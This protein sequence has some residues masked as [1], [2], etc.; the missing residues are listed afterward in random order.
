MQ[1]E[2]SAIEQPIP[3]Q[4]RNNDLQRSRS[5]DHVRV[6][7]MLRFLPVFNPAVLVFGKGFSRTLFHEKQD[8]VSVMEFARD[9]PQGTCGNDPRVIDV[10]HSQFDLHPREHRETDQSDRHEDQENEL[11]PSARRA[12]NPVEKEA[13]FSKRR[14]DHP[15]RFSGSP[16]ARAIQRSTQI[17]RS[18]GLSQSSACAWSAR[19]IL[20][21]TV[22]QE[23][24]RGEDLEVGTNPIQGGLS[25]C[26][27]P[28][29]E[30]VPTQR[31]PIR[32]TR[33]KSRFIPFSPMIRPMFK[34]SQ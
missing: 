1:I 10:V 8:R 31:S 3:D 6:G 14:N 28:K 20:P 11:G 27:A 34:R 32:S 2:Q 24:P 13:N 15:M 16:I 23:A 5:G 7:A 30:K 12:K 21:L 26:Q 33:S 25:I 9:L 18:I 4:R 22:R 17:W 19:D 29:F